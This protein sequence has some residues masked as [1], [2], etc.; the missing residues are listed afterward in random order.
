MNIHIHRESERESMHIHIHIY[1]YMYMYVH[2]GEDV[3]QDLSDDEHMDGIQTGE[4]G[5]GDVQ[6]PTESAGADA[7]VDVW[8]Q[9]SSWSDK[10]R[11]IYLYVC[12]YIYIIYIKNIAFQLFPRMYWLF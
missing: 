7:F 4:G 8:G 11:Y 5:A 3:A 9:L 1:M 6:E 2:T 12:I 10:V